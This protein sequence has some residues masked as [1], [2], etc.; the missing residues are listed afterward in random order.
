ML[1]AF[2]L[3]AVRGSFSFAGG[4]DSALAAAVADFSKKP[5]FLLAS[6]GRIWP[7]ARFE[8]KAG[9]HLQRLLAGKMKLSFVDENSFGFGGD[10]YP[11]DFFYKQ[12]ISLYAA[13]FRDEKADDEDP[14]DDFFTIQTKRNGAL[15]LQSIGSLKF[16]KPLR[17]HWFFDEVRLA[18]SIKG[19]TEFE[20]LAAVAASLGAKLSETPGFYMLDFQPA[21]LRSRMRVFGTGPLPA[22]KKA[23]DLYQSMLLM[24]A[25]DSQLRE[26]YADP[27]N[28]LELPIGEDTPLHRAALQRFYARY[29]PIEEGQNLGSSSERT[30]RYLQEN[31]DFSKAPIA[32]IRADGVP[33]TKFYGKKQGHFIVM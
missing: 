21:L 1:A 28:Q 31:V 32:I 18:A 20:T 26:V 17:W 3:I 11:R 29:K 24:G 27:G 22:V 23:D 14:R 30:Y 5:V 10:A 33:A 2:L 4:D 9:D 16:K 6:A 8:V 25:S 19:A 7:K 13:G 15:T 12:S